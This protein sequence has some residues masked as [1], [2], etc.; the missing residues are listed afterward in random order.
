MQGNDNPKI[1][2]VV[3]N[4]SNPAVIRAAT[5]LTGAYVATSGIRA[6]GNNARMLVDFTISGDAV[7]AGTIVAYLQSANVDVPTEADWVSTHQL[8]SQTAAA[9][10][11]ASIAGAIQVIPVRAK[12]YPVEVEYAVRVTADPAVK[13]RIPIDLGYGGHYRF[14]VRAAGTAG[15]SSAAAV[16]TLPT[17]AISVSLQ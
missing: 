16:S 13:V 10:N 14:Q 8:L 6:S 2:V 3:G 1:Q 7:A 17:V 4:P 15:V 11:V 5:V 12:I 9:D